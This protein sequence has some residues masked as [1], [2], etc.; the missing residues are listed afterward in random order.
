MN[1]VIFNNS[2]NPTLF[3]DGSFKVTCFGFERIG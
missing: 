3:L 1:F 2:L